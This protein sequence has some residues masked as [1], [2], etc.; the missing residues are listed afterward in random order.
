VEVVLVSDEMWAWREEQLGDQARRVK[1]M[2]SVLQWSYASI[3]GVCAMLL[4]FTYLF[5]DE[6]VLVFEIV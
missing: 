4:G 5:A 6:V 2:F 3:A 1:S